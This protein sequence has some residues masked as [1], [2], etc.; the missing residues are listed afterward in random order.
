MSNNK[1]NIE[2]YHS[3]IRR[4]ENGFTW[5][6]MGSSPKGNVT[7]TINIKCERWWLTYL[8]KDLEKVLLEEE[9]EINRIRDLMTLES[10]NNNG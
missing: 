7:K 2:P 6:F 3:E 5:T 4:Y 10:K 8:F 9:S 1:I